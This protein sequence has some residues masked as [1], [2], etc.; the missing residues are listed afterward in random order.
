MSSEGK[1]SQ[2][3]RLLKFISLETLITMSTFI[4]ALLIFVFLAHGIFRSNIFL[5]DQWA[6]EFTDYY[7]SEKLTQLMQFISFLGSHLFLIP[8]NLVLII[9]FIKKNDRWNSIKIPTVAFTS[10]VMMFLMKFIFHRIRPENPLLY[11]AAGFSFPSGHALMS[12]TFYGLILYILIK[13]QDKLWTRLLF[14]LLFITIIIAIGL[15]R[16]Y[17]RVHYASDVIAGFTLGFV[18]LMISLWILSNLEKRYFKRTKRTFPPT[19]KV[20]EY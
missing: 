19:D 1:Q 5:F 2:F 12:V 14:S 20:K 15:S 9:L 3:K 11:E 13:D 18:W 16:I 7:I 8:A 10:V 17:L 6:F 4:A